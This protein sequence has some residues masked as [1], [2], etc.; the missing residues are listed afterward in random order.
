M[1][2]VNRFLVYLFF[3]VKLQLSPATSAVLWDAKTAFATRVHACSLDNN[4]GITIIIH[5]TPVAAVPVFLLSC[6]GS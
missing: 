4:T 5:S 1:E 6:D 3:S 2:Q